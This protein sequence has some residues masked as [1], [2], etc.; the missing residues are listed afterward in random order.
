MI[1]IVYLILGGAAGTLTRYFLS[2]SIYGWWG[3]NF[4]YGTLVVNC[5]GCFIIGILSGIS[6]KGFLLGPE[7]R[8]LLMV[9][10]CGAFTTFSAFILETNTLLKDGEVFKAFLNVS[11]SVVF[12]FVIFRIGL[13]LGEII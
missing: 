2:S 5:A 9:G 1:K 7:T 11:L 8:T 13:L 10:F 12:G 6:D 4:P 3:V